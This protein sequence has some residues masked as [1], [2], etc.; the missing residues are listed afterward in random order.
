MRSTRSQC[1][2]HPLRLPTN[3][4]PLTNDLSSR[5]HI[6]HMQNVVT[7]GVG[8][9]RMPFLITMHFVPWEGMKCILKEPNGADATSKY[10]FAG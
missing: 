2:R 10:A 5:R 1:P 3:D 6:R 7:R 4:S 9:R 8:G